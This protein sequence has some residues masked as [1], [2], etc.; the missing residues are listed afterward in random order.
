MVVGT[1]NDPI[2]PLAAT[3]GMAEALEGGV[4][5]TVDANQHTGYGA[6]ECVDNAV[7]RYLVDLTVPA[8]GLECK[9]G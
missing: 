7:D 5:V 6:N 1:T 9:G 8:A 3:R 2:T 4:L